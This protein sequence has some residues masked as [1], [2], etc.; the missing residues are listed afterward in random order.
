MEYYVLKIKKPWPVPFKYLIL[1]SKI[2]INK[3]SRLKL[4]YCWETAYGSCLAAVDLKIAVCYFKMI[5]EINEK[6]RQL[7]YMNSGSTI[8]S[9]IYI[10]M[11]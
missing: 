3:D 7:I 8:F 2:R 1:L 6:K 11:Y 9:S 10:D 5:E 4:L